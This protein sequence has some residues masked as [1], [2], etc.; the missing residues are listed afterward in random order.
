MSPLSTLEGVAAPAGLPEGL[1]AG[2]LLREGLVPIATPL[3]P[4]LPAIVP[5]GPQHLAGMLELFNEIVASSTAVYADLPE[6]L[7]QRATWLAQR[8]ERGHPVLVAEALDGSVLGFASFGDFRGCFPGFRHTA[9]HSVHLRPAARGQGLGGR[10]VEALLREAR[11]QGRHAMMAS[12]DSGNAPS[13][14]LH[15][16]L[17]FREVG[18]LPQ[19]GAKFGQWLE[20]VLMQKLLDERPTPES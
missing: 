8:Q 12:I 18:R 17:G 13:L 6:T 4:L 14:R 1:I 2:H 19:V 20:L 5:A 3:P 9:E 16:R 7:E 10:L 11:A 15:A